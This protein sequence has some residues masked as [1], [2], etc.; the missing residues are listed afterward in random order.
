MRN[1]SEVLVHENNDSMTVEVLKTAK[2]VKDGGSVATQVSELRML[3]SRLIEMASHQFRTPLSEALS[4]AYLIGQYNREDQQEK[5]AMHLDRIITSV[6]SLTEILDDFLAVGKL[7]DDKVVTNFVYFDVKHKIS[8]MIV[9]L[10]N[11]CN[12]K[13]DIVYEHIGDETKVILDPVLLK[14]A[15]LHLLSNAIKFSSGACPILI[16]TRLTERH[17]EVSVKNQGIGIPLTEQP[18]L[19]R[20]FYRS[21]NV[22]NIQGAGMGLYVAKR[23]VELMGGTIGFTSEPGKETEFTMGFNIITSSLN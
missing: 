2:N 4:S 7:K 18:N 13:M 17:F 9:D 14:G 16:T 23:Y 19:F 10:N 11:Y 21:D 15:M 6:N 3:K 8:K 20:L 22:A 12:L 1:L 5:R